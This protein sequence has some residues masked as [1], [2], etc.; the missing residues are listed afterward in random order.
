MDESNNGVME[1]S[2]KTDNNIN[3][4]VTVYPAKKSV[5]QLFEEQVDAAPDAI[6]AI[7]QGESIS[8]SELASRVDHLASYL[9]SEGVNPGN[10]VAIFMNRSIY[11]LVAL[12]ASIKSGAVYVPVDLKLP[13]N[14]IQFILDDSD[15]KY[16]IVGED[17]PLENIDIENRTLVFADAPTIYQNGFNV[18]S[19]PYNH[20]S[21]VYCIYTSGSTGNPKGV[22]VHHKGLVNYIRWA[23]GQYIKEGVR[24]FAFYSPL[25]FDLTVTSVYVSLISGIT[26]HIYP[27]MDDDVPVIN[28]VVADNKVEIIK[29][30]PS[31]LAL[32]KNEDLS[33]SRINTLI[34]GGEDLKVETAKDIYKKHDGKVAIY[35]EYGP[36]ETVVGCMIYLFDPKKDR[37]GS[38][39]I[40]KAIDNM[41]IYLLDEN[42]QP[43][44]GGETGEIYIGGDGVSLGYRNR[45]DLTEKNYL[46]DPFNPGKIMYAS[47]DLGKYNA[48][49]DLVYLGRR[50]FQIKLQGYRIELGDIENALL[51]YPDVQACTVDSSHSFTVK[52]VNK[53]DIQYCVKC[54][55][56]STY[57]NTTFNEEQVCNHCVDFEKYRNVTDEYFSDTS[58]LQHIID[59]IKKENHPKYDCI[60]S[61][62]GGK[63]ST[64][65]LCKIREMGARI[66]A[67]TL[68]NGYISDRAKDNIARVVA[69]LG[70]DH[71]Y[72]TTEHMNEIFVDSLQ[73]H[74]DVCNGCFKTIYTMAINLAMELGV[75]YVVTG[76]SKGQLFETRLSE[77]FREP[78]FREDQ[79][80][81]NLVEARKIYHRVDDAANRLL[82]NEWV[83][84]DEILEKIRFVD[85]YRYTNVV[86]EEMYEYIEKEVGWVRPPDTGRSTNCLLNDVAIYVHGLERGYHKYSVPYSWDVRMG[87]IERDEAIHELD[88]SAEIDEVEVNTILDELGYKI[89]TDDGELKEEYLVAY[90]KAANDIPSKQLTDHLSGML[91]EY[92]IPAHFVH[93]DKIPLTLNGKVNKK[94]LPRPNSPRKN[95]AADYV[96]PRN[97]TEEKLVDIWKEILML[98]KVGVEDDFFEIGGHS[99]P[100]LMLLFKIDNHFD[101]IVSIQEFSEVP[102]ISGLVKILQTRK[103]L[104][105]V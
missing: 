24:N 72:M 68:D 57:P 25:V 33:G 22:V 63:D 10:S 42:Q 54:G 14:R 32:L 92:M 104:E 60:V 100:A 50:D 7:Y 87:H 77:I 99:L 97:E 90:Y 86:R 89:K 88:D 20:E 70:V 37:Y 80:E 13:K 95:N 41:W 26:I 56:S 46:A 45:P 6:A 103:Q 12:L 43:V 44:A 53:S 65:A 62:S 40:G 49:G 83:G 29:L 79:F 69:S 51:S 47:G 76:L 73:R 28:K 101:E 15:I 2:A 96:A 71:R 64:Y 94:A 3:A 4:G 59:T 91:P 1:N 55:I 61:L 48:A 78:V 35:N 34:L 67:F 85:F 84:H 38:V 74:S 52:E 31:H 9:I 21:P 5:I 93:L 17:S 102:T 16:V 19:M 58:H 81:R 27:D 8:Y 18:V 75:N 39:P 30:T 98:D 105:A 23:K 36:T 66:F 11:C 82:N